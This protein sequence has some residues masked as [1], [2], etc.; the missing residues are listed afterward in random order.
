MNVSLKLSLLFLCL[1]TFI[2]LICVWF[3]DNMVLQI[4]SLVIVFLLNLLRFSQL[5]IYQEIKLLIPFIVTMFSIYAV[6]GLVSFPPPVAT[7]PSSLT[8]FSFWIRYGVLRSTL[9]ISTMLYVQLILSF[10]SINDLLQLPFSIHYKKVLILGKALFTAAIHSV[11]DLE[12]QLRLLPQFQ[13]PH[14]SV[15]QWFRFKL[16]LSL[17]LIIMLL[18]ESKQKGELIDNRI[19]HCFR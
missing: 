15:K 10:I 18:R 19:K 12:L 5:E 3:I 16:T 9:F 2:T 4:L 13:K 1:M 17:A 6:L 8:P 14:L 11:S 7:P